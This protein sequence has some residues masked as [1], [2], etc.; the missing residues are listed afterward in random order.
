MEC[1]ICKKII[2][3]DMVAHLRD[4]C[5]TG[6]KSVIVKRTNIVLD[7]DIICK[8]CFLKFDKRTWTSHSKKV[9]NNNCK[10]GYFA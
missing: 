3:S 4:D 1:P 5:N 10:N 6:A 9:K 2:A 7:N 8:R